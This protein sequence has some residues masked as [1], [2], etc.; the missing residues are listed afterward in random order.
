MNIVTWKIRFLLAELSINSLIILPTKGHI[1][2][3]LK[4]LGNG[5]EGLERI[6]NMAMER[7]ESQGREC[8]DLAKQILTWI[9]H[10]R[11]P[12]FTSELQHAVSVRS[13]ITKL[14]E[15]YL[16]TIDRLRS[17]C[18]GLVTIDEGSD[19]IRLVH[20]TTQE[21]FERIGGRWKLDPQFYIASTCLTYLSFDV[22]KTG[23]CSSD[24][25]FE[26]RLRENKF[27]DYAAKYWGKHA[28][29]VEGEVC[30]LAYSCLSDSELVSSA[31]QAL[32]VRKINYRRYSQIYPQKSTGLHLA[33]R[34]GL[35]LVLETMLPE[36]EGE[37][38]TALEK[39]DSHNQDLL[40]VAASAGH[41]KT[42]ELLLEK[43]A[44]P[45]FKGNYF[46]YALQAASYGGHKAIVKMLLENGAEINAQGQVYGDAL[47]A[48][49]ATH[50]NE[51]VDLLVENGA[52]SVLKKE[53]EDMRYD[54]SYDKNTKERNTS[55][56]SP[57]TKPGIL[58]M[59]DQVQME[60]RR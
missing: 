52:K 57:E 2:E 37:R 25:T 46:Y 9:V 26:Q 58:L 51:V 36:H 32:L 48:A 49:K 47:T 40:Y 38:T 45:N 19:I 21:Y 43:G 1:K 35:S 41:D 6:Y 22:F 53:E 34:L 15:D 39:R 12:L 4:N 29:I 56:N 16:P 54:R 42:V 7:I 59:K 33:A 8:R 23:G 5:M 30:G 20:Y 11:R 18:A 60:A 3:A 17:L 44:D 10:A 13:N 31:T 27:L 28:A 14:D 50:H 55:D 24:K